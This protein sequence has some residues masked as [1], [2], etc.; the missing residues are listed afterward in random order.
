MKTTK[1]RVLQRR[2]PDTGLSF[3][4]GVAF[5]R[6]EHPALFVPAWR[7]SRSLNAETLESL[8]DV[9]FPS[10]EKDCWEW[11]ELE[12]TTDSFSHPIDLFQAVVTRLTSESSA[13][14]SSPLDSE[15]EG[16]CPPD[17]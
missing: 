11:G 2:Q 8:D 6:V 15:A 4:F 13:P 3:P 14:H 10:D 7:S 1:Y 12:T 9:D 16:D 5:E 17:S